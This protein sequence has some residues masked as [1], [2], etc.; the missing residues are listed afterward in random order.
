MPALT[1]SDAARMGRESLTMATPG[2]HVTNTGAVLLA[3]E[4]NKRPSHRHIKDG[5]AVWTLLEN[6]STH[7]YALTPHILQTPIL[8]AAHPCRPQ[9]PRTRCHPAARP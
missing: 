5:G 4:E 8:H 6:P 1:F 3:C 2:A 7:D 9:T